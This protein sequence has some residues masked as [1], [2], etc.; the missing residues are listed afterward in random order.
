MDVCIDVNVDLHGRTDRRGHACMDMPRVSTVFVDL[1]V[2]CL[3]MMW[4]P[5]L[6]HS[7]PTVLLH[8]VCTCVCGNVHWHVR[9]ASAAVPACTLTGSVRN[10]QQRVQL[11]T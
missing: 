3:D 11:L 5:A 6:S 8:T 1:C 10:I 9:Y 7:E 4:S 2:M